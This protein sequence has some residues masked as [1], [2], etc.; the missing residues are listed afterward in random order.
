MLLI[1][2]THYNAPA[3]AVSML[4][5]FTHRPHLAIQKTK[6]IFIVAGYYSAKKDSKPVVK[7]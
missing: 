4:A 5:F 1:M 3:R 6:E 2:R 7:L